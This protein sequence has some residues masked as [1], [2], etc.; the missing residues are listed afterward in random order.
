MDVYNEDAIFVVV[1][2]CI[3]AF[4][5]IVQHIKSTILIDNTYN[6]CE[7]KEPVSCRRI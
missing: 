7:T 1:Y 3:I 5:I 4:D 6:L 2:L